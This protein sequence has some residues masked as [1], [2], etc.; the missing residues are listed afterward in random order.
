M[1]QVSSVG[2]GSDISKV[3]SALVANDR[4]GKVDLVFENTGDND[5]VVIVKEFN[6]TSWTSLITY[7]TVKAKGTITK[8]AVLLNKT[9]GFFGSGNTTVNVTPVFRNPADRRGAQIDM[10]YPGRKGW[11]FDVGLDSGTMFN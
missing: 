2:F 9:I 5:A 11:T 8:S 4:L 7:F 1:N 10:L 3:A 6:G